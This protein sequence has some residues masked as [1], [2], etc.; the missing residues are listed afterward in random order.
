M[1]CDLSFSLLDDLVHDPQ[2]LMFEIRL[3]REF[4]DFIL[5]DIMGLQREVSSFF[6]GGRR[7]RC[8]KLVLSFAVT[9]SKFPLTFAMRSSMSNWASLAAF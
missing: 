7:R 8:R 3:T 2:D 5:S 1:T 4:S 6:D 9:H